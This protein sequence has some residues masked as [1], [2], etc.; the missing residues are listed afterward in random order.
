MTGTHP[1]DDAVHTGTIRI[2]TGDGV[3]EAFTARTDPAGPGVLLYMDAF[4]LRPQIERMAARIAAWGFTVLAPSV[5]YRSGSAAE[6][7]P[8]RDLR[9]PGAREEFFPAVAPRMQAHTPAQAA[10]DA[11]AYA[12]ALRELAAPHPR[13]AAI[14]YCMGGRLALR[15][16][17]QLPGQVAAVG[18]FHTGGLVTDAPDSPH[19][20]IPGL[21]AEVL[22][23]Y[24]DNDGS[25]PPEAI[26]AVEAALTR[27]GVPFSS[28]VYAGAP[29]G[30]TM[31]D[32]SAY[33]ADAA[34][35][36]YTEL[37]E[38]LTRTLASPA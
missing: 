14:G 28:A 36:H 12:A 22:A 8:P 26:T 21:R 7:A 5:F 25:M 23:R 10:D 24:A 35:R 37:R 1:A 13:W 16:A 19:L 4:G 29:H 34:E 32:T 3:A 17:A 11:V 18:M 27:A 20:C 33:D 38:L 6:L 15:A 2:D 31:D 30:Y 9:E